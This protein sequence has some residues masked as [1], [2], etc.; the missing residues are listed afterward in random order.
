[1][2]V[3]GPTVIVCSEDVIGCSGDFFVWRVMCSTRLSVSTVVHT[4]M[5]WAEEAFYAFELLVMSLMIPVTSVRRHLL[6]ARIVLDNSA[7]VEDPSLCV[8]H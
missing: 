5:P 1:M 3:W 7:R 2:R 8:G 4:R 6:R